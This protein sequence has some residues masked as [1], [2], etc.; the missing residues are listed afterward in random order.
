MTF[1]NPSGNGSPYAHGR[2]IALRVIERWRSRG[3]DTLWC[4]PSGYCSP[5]NSS[6][7]RS[8]MPEGYCCYPLDSEAALTAV[9]AA[10]DAGATYR[11]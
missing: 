1:D 2:S 7:T 8:A 6:A 9:A 5:A 10:I 4:Y 11:F 3:F